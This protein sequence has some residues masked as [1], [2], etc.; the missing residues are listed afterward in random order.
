MGDTVKWPDGLFVMT[1]VNALGA[2]AP[3]RLADRPPSV[4]D[5]LRYN[6]T[7][8]GRRVYHPTV[9]DATGGIHM[10]KT[11][12]ADGDDQP[13]TTDQQQQQNFQRA[14]QEVIDELRDEAEVELF[15]ENLQW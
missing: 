11:N 8:D 10:S 5:Y 3:G 12:T 4:G 9:R 13:V 1:S 15:E 6:D 14:V 7:R 2:P